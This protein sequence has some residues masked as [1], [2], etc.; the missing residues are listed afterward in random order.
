MPD[1]AVYLLKASLL[2]LPVYLLYRLL[3]RRLTFYTYNRLFLLLGLSGALLFPVLDLSWVWVQPLQLKGQDVALQTLTALPLVPK[4]Q[5]PKLW[6]VLLLLYA[7]GAALA[8]IRLLVQVGSLLRLYLCS[9]SIKLLDYTVRQLPGLQSPFSFGR[10]IFLDPKC[11]KVH[12][13]PYLLQHESV[14]VKQ[15]HTLDVLLGQLCCVVLWFNP[16]TWLLQRYL[17][18]N[19]EYIA[20]A[21]VLRQGTN[22]KAYQ[23]SLLHSG[24]LPH[25]HSFVLH[26][27]LNPIK[28]RIMMMNKKRSSALQK[29]QY[30]LFVP[31][32]LG[33]GLLSSHTQAG[34]LALPKYTA[35]SPATQIPTDTIVY[36]VNGERI[37]SQDVKM[38]N[39]NTIA[40]IEVLKG[41]AAKRLASDPDLK[42]VVKITLKQGD[43]ALKGNVE[44]ENKQVGESLKTMPENAIY[45]LDDKQ[46]TYEQLIQL[47]PNRI[48][49][50]SILKD[51]PKMIDKY[52]SG[53]RSGVIFIY[54]K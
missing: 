1:L 41:E 17:R 25:L 44:I 40:K 43:A 33:L 48:K 30:A 45:I 20:D 6:D 38:L 23:Y 3:L 9:E 18:Q 26:F 7:A 21:Q 37:P 51:S 5:N 42:G 35:K 29:L 34:E 15:W 39:P 50:V 22:R 19:L 36:L 10:T 47:S 16:V 24:H 28:T 13:L 53:A 46:V 31:V 12:E 8:A 27:N 49:G 52:G 14:H 4:D 32:L 2:L 11:H 54:T